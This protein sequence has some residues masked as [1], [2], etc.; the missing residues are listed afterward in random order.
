MSF[1]VIFFSVKFYY[2]ISI[3][4]LTFKHRNRKKNINFIE[5]MKVKIYFICYKIYLTIKKEF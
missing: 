2:S 5:D 1:F 3:S 4:C